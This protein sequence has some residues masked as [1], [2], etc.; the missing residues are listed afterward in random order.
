M[1]ARKKIYIALNFD[2]S[3]YSEQESD[4]HPVFPRIADALLNKTVIQTEHAR[5]YF[6]E[7]EFYLFSET[8]PDPFVHKNE[9]QREF[10]QWYL[11]GSGFDLCLG[12]KDLENQ[13]PV[14][15]GILIRSIKKE[16]NGSLICGPVKV[17]DTLIAN[18]GSA[19]GT[20]CM[21][22]ETLSESK[23]FEI[24]SDERI[25][26]KKPALTE[27]ESPMGKKYRE[28]KYRFWVHDLPR[29]CPELK[30]RKP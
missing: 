14:Y 11:H 2:E 9:Q 3:L 5:F 30:K 17:C 7:I 21:K 22:I 29:Y 10:G 23:N 4:L 18:Y 24:K 28:M 27:E 16:E 1:E 13:Q 25:G 26:L 15:F 6:Q 8:H 19:F 20:G 12:N